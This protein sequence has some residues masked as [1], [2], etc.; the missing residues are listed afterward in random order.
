MH[1]AERSRDP[2]LDFADKKICCDK[3]DIGWMLEIV[4]PYVAAYERSVAQYPNIKPG[5]EFA[6]YAKT[7]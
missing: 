3:M 1:M 2:I 7:K 4:F 5:Q 6:G